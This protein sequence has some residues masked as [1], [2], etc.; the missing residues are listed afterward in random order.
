MKVKPRDQIKPN[1]LVTYK[2]RPK[3]PLLGSRAQTPQEMAVLW[4]K[5]TRLICHLHS[6]HVMSACSLGVS[7]TRD[8][9][10]GREEEEEEEEEEKYK[11]IT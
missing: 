4:R 2:I 6:A 5:A 7:D 1:P 9:G 3:E 10:K 8:W 11:G